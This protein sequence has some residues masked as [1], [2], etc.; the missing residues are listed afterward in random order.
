MLFGMLLIFLRSRNFS[1]KM[2]FL[3]TRWAQANFAILLLY[4]TNCRFLNNHDQKLSNDVDLNVLYWVRYLSYCFMHI[5]NGQ[6]TSWKTSLFFILHYH[7]Y[8]FVFAA[9]EIVLNIESLL[10]RNTNGST[11][12][13]TQKI[14][15]S[16][17][18]RKQ[19]FHFNNAQGKKM[20]VDEASAVHNA[21][22]YTVYG[23]LITFW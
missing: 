18:P 9:H 19:V 5:K 2:G 20:M 1:W 22:H 10:K 15:L 6:K 23:D 16:L 3:Q 21:K 17:V 7:Q 12:H 4:T 11:I 8:W 13:L 14:W